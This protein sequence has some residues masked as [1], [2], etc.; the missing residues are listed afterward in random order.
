MAKVQ[1]GPLVT[2]AEGKLN[3]RDY[4]SRRKTRVIKQ[5]LG[6][7]FPDTPQQRRVREYKRKGTALW[8]VLDNWYFGEP[9]NVELRF[10]DVWGY[11]QRTVVS[12]Q[13]RAFVGSMVRQF[14]LLEQD[15]EGVIFTRGALYAP[16]LQM[17]GVDAQP[18]Y[19]DVEFRTPRRYHRDTILGLA[20]IVVMP[21]FEI[22]G[23]E[24]RDDFF[25]V[26][27]PV[28]VDN[29]GTDYVG[30]LHR[31]DEVPQWADDM[32]AWG[33]MC[34]V[35]E[36]L[37]EFP[38]PLQVRPGPTTLI[39][40][41]RTL[42]TMVRLPV[43]MDIP[44]Q[45]LEV[46]EQVNLDLR[47]F[48]DGSLPITIDVMGLPQGLMAEN[49]LITG[50]VQEEGTYPI[51]VVARNEFGQTS[52]S[53][54]ITAELTTMAPVWSMIDVGT[55]QTNMEST[56]NL[57]DFVSGNPTPVITLENPRNLEQGLMVNDGVI[58]GTPQ[59]GRNRDLTFRAMNSAG[60]VDITI[61]LAVVA[62]GTVR[63]EVPTFTR[64]VQNEEVYI[65][66]WQ[67]VFNATSFVVDP[68]SQVGITFRNGIV[69]GLSASE[70]RY[71]W[72]IT[73]RRGVLGPP[74]RRIA[75]NIF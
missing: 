42:R 43:W 66:M 18:T 17:L 51:Q 5:R 13:E 3:D 65:D 56:L 71:F 60:M 35:R 11:V 63:E 70:G 1:L 55:W 58:S 46:G 32:L 21:N 31:P 7:D 29:P 74:T 27:C 9:R 30:R 50:A 24:L 33:F 36:D 39:S 62:V 61:N 10:D 64:I 26:Y 67:Y 44:D 72:D 22:E 19:I 59:N 4:T 37:N 75:F 12:P 47:T 25:A 23:E 8:N 6:T 45:M 52:T 34:Y 48:V 57:N 14:D 68:T 41:S 49:G 69:T 2:Y 40:E 28:R 54:E 16:V 53:F 20:F 15:G 38:Q 73:V